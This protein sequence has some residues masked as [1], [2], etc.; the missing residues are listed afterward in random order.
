[1]FPD[2][3]LDI[4][5]VSEFEGHIQE[6]RC[7]T[8]LAISVL[9]I[10]QPANW[11]GDPAVTSHWCL[12]HYI[13]DGHHKLF[14]ASRAKQPVGLLSILALDRGVSGPEQHARLISAQ[15]VESGG[16]ANRSQQT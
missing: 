7:P 14:A 16:L 1:M 11:D 3:W 5:R 6:G 15:K 13:I 12:A 10:K 8:V 9:D 4:K 2:S